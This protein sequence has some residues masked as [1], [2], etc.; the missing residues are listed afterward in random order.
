MPHRRRKRFC[1]DYPRPCVTVDTVLVDVARPG[2]G[3]LLIRR[4]GEP[5]KGC[6]ALP[7]G[8]VEEDESLEEAA[9]RELEEE[10]MLRGVPLEQFG[11]FGDPK[12]DPRARVISVAYVALVDAQQMSP[13]P[14]D[15]AAAVGWF[16]CKSL[17]KLAFDHDAVITVALRHLREA[18]EHRPLL[19]H[20]LPEQFT[21]TELR[22]L[23]E[24]IL[25]RRLEPR[26]F[27][28]RMLRTGLVERA[29]S[30]GRLLRFKK[31]TAA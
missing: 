1:Y 11:A 2:L 29:K 12:R 16:S 15:D 5:F 18:I 30:A 22:R 21:L 25:G 8:F 19:R 27:R 28:Q 31:Q 14:S 26:E 3:V 20:L 4:G 13:H 10:T 17:P 23:H 9:R 24:S 6:W 7:G